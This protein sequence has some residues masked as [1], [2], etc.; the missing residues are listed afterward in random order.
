MGRN[1]SPLPMGA[2]FTQG[3]DTQLRLCTAPAARGPAIPQSNVLPGLKIL[4][5][6]PRNVLPNDNYT[7]LFAEGLHTL[8]SKDHTN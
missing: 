1:G 5:W 6:C 7:L 8:H 2:E 4:P 3:E